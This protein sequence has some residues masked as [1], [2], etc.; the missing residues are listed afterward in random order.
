MKQAF[1]SDNFEYIIDSDG[2]Q[3]DYS[4]PRIVHILT[5]IT[6]PFASALAEKI[7]R[8]Y[9]KKCRVVEKTNAE[10]MQYAKRLCSGRECIPMTAM[11]GASLKDADTRRQ[12][13]EISIYFTLDQEGPCQNGAWPTVWDIYVKR[14]NQK[15]IIAGVN[16][17]RT[18]NNLGLKKNH[19]NELNTSVL[20]GDFFEEAYHSLRCL[21]Q[22]RESALEIFNKAFSCFM[23]AFVAKGV[24]VEEALHLWAE[25]VSEIPLKARV[26]EVPK[27]LIFGGLN[28]LFIHFPISNYFIEQGIIPK[29]IDI[30]EGTC[31]VE[32]EDMFRHG[33]RKGF[34]SPSEQFAYSPSRKEDDRA[35]EIRKA[36]FGLKV[37]ESA[38]QRYREAMKPSG[39][40]F[41]N[42]IPFQEIVTAGHE[43]ASNNGFT[44]TTVTTGRYICSAKNGLFDGLVNMGSFNCQPAMNSQAIIRPL[45]NTFDIPYIALDCEGPWISTNQQRLLETLAVQA[46]RN[47]ELKGFH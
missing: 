13:D 45:T 15:N 35:V 33:F 9:D 4:D 34:I 24:A 40:V 19:L 38:Q 10:T 18:K 43:F 30:A 28:L 44:E 29:V 8:K 37:I 1:I 12:P 47:H 31:W 17:N 5:D 32:S 23:D 2:Q 6:S 39:L 20:L 42:L 27:V 16:R 26:N 21:A 11:V 46:K 41:D 36:R 3:I 25:G 22:D 14:L 7:Y